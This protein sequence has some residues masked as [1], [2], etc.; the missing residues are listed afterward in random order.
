M[1]QNAEEAALIRAVLAGERA[2]FERL[3]RK[4]ERLVLHIVTPI[5]G[6]GPERD[7]I[8]QETFIKVYTNLSSFQF[9]SK[10]SSWIGRI[11]YNHGI[12]F[13]TK[14]KSASFSQLFGNDDNA[15]NEIA[16][17][18]LTSDEAL[19]EAEHVRDLS[20]AMQQL[21]PIQNSILLL[22]HYDDMSLDEIAKLMDISVGAVKTHLFRGRRKLKE[23]LI[24]KLQ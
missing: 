12:N 7:D 24:S 16:D 14:K 6:T 11:A 3:I 8:C 15:L 10:L 4:Y 17:E 5:V 23:A 22:F 1:E 21:P 9:K 20:S 2:A 19:I 13:V 18:V